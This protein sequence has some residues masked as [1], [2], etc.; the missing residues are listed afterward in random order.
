M[1][2]SMSHNGRRYGQAGFA[3]ILAL[4]ALLLLTFLGLTLAAT[5]STELQ[6]A[7]NY[8]WGQ[9]ATYIAQTALDIARKQLR[10]QTTWQIFLPVARR[11][12][13]DMMNPPQWAPPVPPTRDFENR[14][15]DTGPLGGNQGYGVVLWPAGFAAPYQNV[16]AVPGTFGVTA[17]TLRGAFTIWIRRTPEVQPN[18]SVLDSQRDDSA[19]LT[20]EG[21][22][23]FEG[24]GGPVSDYQYRRRATRVLEVEITKTDPNDCDGRTGQTGNSP[25]GSGYDPCYGVTGAGLP[26]APAEVNRNQN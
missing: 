9:Q 16:S 12:P 2:E 19:I 8:R 3:L 5:T 22:S 18:G 4:L 6:I 1:S 11:L 13:A 7:T 14:A 17:E 10:E 26:G 24:V 25:T 15:C 21:T 23:P 20:V